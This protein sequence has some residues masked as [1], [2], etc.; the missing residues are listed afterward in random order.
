MEHVYSYNPGACMGHSVQLQF[1]Q[2]MFMSS[3]CQMAVELRRMGVLMTDLL[4][5]LMHQ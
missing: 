5:L 3:G 2:L 1:K 4:V